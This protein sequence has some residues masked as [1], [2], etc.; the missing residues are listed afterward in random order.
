MSES[1][2]ARFNAFV[3]D[4]V[5]LP[6][7]DVDGVSHHLTY[8]ET[9]S[10]VRQMSNTEYYEIPPSRMT[11]VRI[12]TPDG[13]FHTYSDPIQ[14]PVL[15]SSAIFQIQRLC[16][17]TMANNPIGPNMTHEQLVESFNAYENMRVKIWY[18]YDQWARIP[19]SESGV[20]ESVVAMN[21]RILLQE[22]IQ[23]GN[24]ILRLVATKKLAGNVLT[25]N[26]LKTMRQRAVVSVDQLAAI[27]REFGHLL[28]AA[29]NWSK[30]IQQQQEQEQD[31]PRA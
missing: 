7:V 26:D 5:E 1:F 13:L 11:C 22:F 29:E 14:P 24:V 4:E 17:E 31:Q 30:L 21:V 6:G 18:A 15:G 25:S 3:D 23:L 27:D 16:N 28:F 20:N 8:A 12:I 9:G 19:P 10:V 2:E